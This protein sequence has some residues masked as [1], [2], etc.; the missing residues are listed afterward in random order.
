MAQKL[1]KRYSVSR[2]LDVFKN[3]QFNQSGAVDAAVAPS[4]GFGLTVMQ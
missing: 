2:R 1:F 3:I 4:N